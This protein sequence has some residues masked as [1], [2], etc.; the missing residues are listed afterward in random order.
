VDA[1]GEV[2]IERTT[3]D[4]ELARARHQSNTGDRRLA[5]PGGEGRRGGRHYVSFFFAV[6]FAAVRF[7][8][9]VDFLAVGFFVVAGFLA[10]VL[11][12]VDFAVVDFAVVDF[13]VVDF[14]VVG[15]FAVVLV[16]AD[17]AAA[18]GDDVVVAAG[19]FDSFGAVGD[20]FAAAGV[21]AASPF[22]V[23]FSSVA[24]EPGGVGRPS[25]T[26]RIP[27]VHSWGFCA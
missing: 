2:L 18:F 25:H 12:V 6:G 9:V 22:G 8:A 11:E 3:V 17:V 20:R 23:A 19:S 7:F 1:C 27:I 5:P 4:A 21:S 26:G 10:E 15:F 13:A 16:P 24:T 14:A